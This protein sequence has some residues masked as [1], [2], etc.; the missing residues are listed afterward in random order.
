MFSGNNLLS[1][2]HGDLKAGQLGVDGF[3]VHAPLSE[4]V[5]HVSASNV[6]YAHL[7]RMRVVHGQTVTR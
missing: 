2:Y 1:R 5:R 6:S 4:L 7:E 3:N